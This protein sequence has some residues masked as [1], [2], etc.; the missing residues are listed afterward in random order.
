MH[1]FIKELVT[2]FTILLG[3]IHRRVGI[4]KNSLRRLVTRRTERDPDACGGKYLLSTNVVRLNQ[5]FL[6]ALGHT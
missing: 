6:Q 2:R 1:L 3:T 5:I 4:A